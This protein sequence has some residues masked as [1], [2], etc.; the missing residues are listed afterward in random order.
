MTFPT[1]N[2]APLRLR[3]TDGNGNSSD[4]A[5]FDLMRMVNLAAA[6]DLVWDPTRNRFYASV[7]GSGGG[8]NSNRVLVIDPVSAAISGGILLNQNPG[9]LALTNGGE[10]LYVALNGNGSIVRIDPTS[11]SAASTF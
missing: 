2:A 6:S 11:M 8:T 7:S 9:R 3:A 4:S 1:V 10:N 5:P